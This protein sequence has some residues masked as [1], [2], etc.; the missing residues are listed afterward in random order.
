MPLI[1][2]I[3]VRTENGIYDVT[4]WSKDDKGYYTYFTDD[5]CEP[6]QYIYND[7]I[8]KTANNLEDL[9]DEF[10]YTYLNTPHQ[11]CYYDKEGQSRFINT[12]NDNN[13]ISIKNKVKTIHYIDIKP[14]SDEELKTVKG[15]IW[16]GDDLIC[17][18]EMK[19]YGDGYKLF[20]KESD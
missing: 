9:I 1:E 4:Y 13:G 11:R 16:S 5:W 10:H 8:I 20:L 17:V 19:E 15:Y 14:L 3:Y 7:D 18:A 2:Q 12:E 6:K